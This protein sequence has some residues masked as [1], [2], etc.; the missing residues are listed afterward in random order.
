MG[1]SGQYNYP[2]SLERGDTGAA[3]LAIVEFV[4]S[5]IHAIFLLNHTYL[6]YYKWRFRA[7]RTLPRLS[8]LAPDLEWL[9][10][11]PNGDRDVIQKK[12]TIERIAKSIANELRADMLSDFSRAELEGHAYAVNDSISDST[13][14]NLHILYGV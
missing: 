6:P 2:R 4:Q 1:Q 10:S 7:L 9:I 13:I 3:Q 8:E 11:S 14:R 5:T 12:E